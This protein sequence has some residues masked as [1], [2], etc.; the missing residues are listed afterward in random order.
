MVWRAAMVWTAELRISLY[1]ETSLSLV[2]PEM[3]WTAELRISLYA[4]TSLSRV[5]PEMVWRV[6]MVRT[7]TCG[8]PAQVRITGSQLRQFL[9]LPQTRTPD[10][11]F[12]NVL[13]FLLSS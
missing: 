12:F 8:L 11:V 2:H 1:A 3:V 13:P 4:E 6:A 5:H 9:A 7:R 10:N